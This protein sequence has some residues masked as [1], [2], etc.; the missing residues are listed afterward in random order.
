MTTTSIN[1][2]YAKRSVNV[3]GF[4]WP[5]WQFNQGKEFVLSKFLFFQLE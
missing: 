4:T 2:H 3:K 5:V 1:S